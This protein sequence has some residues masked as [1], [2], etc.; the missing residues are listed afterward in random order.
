MMMYEYNI[1][2]E[3]DAKFLDVTTKLNLNN[4]VL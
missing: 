1:G 2:K 4:V 3:P